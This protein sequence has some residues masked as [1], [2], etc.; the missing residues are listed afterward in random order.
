MLT[1]LE[2]VFRNLKSE[3]DMRPVYH[4][5]A[6]RVES[7][8]WITLLA[9]HLIHHIR[10]WLKDQGIHDSWDTLHQRMRAICLP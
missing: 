9:Y 10:L 6:Q 1:D 4:Q 8:L 5:T 2:A 3:L 7:H